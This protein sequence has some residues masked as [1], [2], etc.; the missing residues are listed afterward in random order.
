M[1]IGMRATTPVS[2]IRWEFWGCTTS[3]RAHRHDRQRGVCG[4]L[5]AHTWWVAST[6]PHA[7]KAKEE[8][9]FV[10]AVAGGG[11]PAVTL[12]FAGTLSNSS[13]SC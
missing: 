6:N 13:V 3:V 11:L 4:A 12:C 1:R 9:F 7:L 10:F 2:V 8:F 5:H